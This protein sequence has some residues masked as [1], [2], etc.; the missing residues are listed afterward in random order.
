[1]EGVS[2]PSVALIIA[3]DYELSLD[4]ELYTNILGKLGHLKLQTL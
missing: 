4:D 2:C 1:M 3:F